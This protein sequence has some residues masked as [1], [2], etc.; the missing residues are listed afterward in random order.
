MNFW[1]K[2]RTYSRFCGI[3]NNI[4]KVNRILATKEAVNTI[5]GKYIGKTNGNS[6]KKGK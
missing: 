1:Q 3:K 4:Q 5:V 6:N 2:S